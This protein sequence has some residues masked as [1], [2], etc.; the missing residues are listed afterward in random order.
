MYNDPDGSVRSE[1]A[2]CLTSLYKSKELLSVDIFRLYDAM[3]YAA[4]RDSFP[5]VKIRALQFWRYITEYYLTLQ[6]M[7]DG[8]FPEMT[9]SK[10][11]KRI[12]QL[13]DEEVAK[14]LLNVLDDLSEN[15][16]LAVLVSTLQ[17]NSEVQTAVMDIMGDFI[18]KLERYGITSISGK[19]KSL[20]KKTIEAD[21]DLEDCVISNKILGREILAPQEFLNI[22]N[23][24]LFDF[25]SKKSTSLTKQI[26]SVLNEI[27]S[28]Q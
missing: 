20:I 9:F 18:N 22:L 14:R 5:K 12:V 23:A 4:M 28:K 1:A 10:K 19:N 16:C 2:T 8:E 27:L 25:H 21:I 3:S 7:L 13:T 26:E 6:G 24:Y 15:G 17:D 11:F